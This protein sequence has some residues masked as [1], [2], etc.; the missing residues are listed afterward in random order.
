[1][2]WPGRRVG[3][4]GEMDGGDGG[5]RVIRPGLPWSSP[6][7]SDCR[8][9]QRADSPVVIP[10]RRKI[11]LGG[12]NYRRLLPHEASL[13]T[14]RNMVPL[15]HSPALAAGANAR[16]QVREKLWQ[17]VEERQITIRDRHGSPVDVDELVDEI[18]G[19]EPKPS[20]AAGAVVIGVAIGL[21]C[22]FVGWIVF[23]LVVRLG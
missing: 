8:S 16:Q 12:T 23:V 14:V 19:P 7:L 10:L 6:R 17:M 4:D 3:S 1:M 18:L 20:K 21:L 15:I 5:Q 22:A 11:R 2:G 9:Q 13:P